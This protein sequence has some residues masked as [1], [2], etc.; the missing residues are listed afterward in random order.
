MKKHLTFLHNKPS[1]FCGAL[2]ILF[3]IALGGCSAVTPN[4]KDAKDAEIEAVTEAVSGEEI[5][6]HDLQANDESFMMGHNDSGHGVIYYLYRSA[7]EDQRADKDH[8]YLLRYETDLL[9][10]TFWNGGSVAVHSGQK[11][12]INGADWHILWTRF[13]TLYESE[14]TGTGEPWKQSES[15]GV[16]GTGCEKPIVFKRTECSNDYQIVT[17]Y[18]DK[19]LLSLLQAE[20]EI[21]GTK[22]QLIGSGDPSGK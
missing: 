21:L 4:T 10:E 12:E 11:G 18:K 7:S 15:V 8:Y 22:K 20:Y 19:G 9:T 17:G 5:C 6:L 2:V 16:W 14:K 13:Y 3:S 1:V